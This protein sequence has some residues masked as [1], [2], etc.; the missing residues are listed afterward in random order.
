MKS[1]LTD[2]IRRIILFLICGAI[3]GFNL[4]AQTFPVQIT[5]TQLPPY[6]PFLSDFSTPGPDRLRLQILLLDSRQTRYQVKLRLT[7]QGNG[8]TIKSNTAI[9]TKPITLDY[10]VPLILTNNELRELFDPATLDFNGISTDGLIKSGKLPEGSY[11][12]CAEVYDFIRDETPISNQGCSIAFLQELDP[13]DI[14]SPGD[15]IIPVFPQQYLVSWIPRHIGLMAVEYQLDIFEKIPGIADQQ[16]SEITNPLIRYRGPFLNYRIS[17]ED[18]Q[19]QIGKEY[20]ARV[21]IKDPSG[22]YTFKND[23]YSPLKTFR[24]GKVCEAPVITETKL[25][26]NFIDVRWTAKEPLKKFDLKYRYK[27]APWQ[28]VSTDNTFYPIPIYKVGG[29]YE[30]QVGSGCYD[31]IKINSDIAKLTLNKKNLPPDYYA[32]GLELELEERSSVPLSEELSAGDTIIAN[33]MRLVLTSINANGGNYSGAGA[34]LF[35]MFGKMGIQCSFSGIGLNEDKEL[36]S[37]S[38]KITGAG[39]KLLKDGQLQLL[40]GL[41]ETLKTSS[42]ILSMATASSA[43]EYLQRFDAFIPADIKNKLDSLQDLIN[44]TTDEIIKGQ[45]AKELELIVTQY[46]DLI[47]DLLDADFQVRFIKDEYQQYGFDGLDPQPL[48]SGMRSEYEKMTIAGYDYYIPYKSLEINKGDVVKAKV[49]DLPPGFEL[50]RIKFRTNLS[51]TAELPATRSGN[52]WSITLPSIPAK[53]HYFVL[54]GYLDEIK[55]GTDSAALVSRVAGM[56]KVKVYPRKTKSVILVPLTTITARDAK[57]VEQEINKIFDQAIVSWSVSTA[58]NY[59][60]PGYD[61]TLDSIR[62][63]FLANYTREMQDIIRGYEKQDTLQYYLFI[64]KATGSGLAGFMPRGRNYGFI[65]SADAKTIAHEL[66][67]GYGAL[68]HT[69][70]N[71]SGLREGSTDL[72]MDYN[73]GVRLT[74]REW[75]MLQNPPGIIPWFQTDTEGQRVIQQS[76]YHDRYVY[77]QYTGAD[78]C[79]ASITPSGQ[80]INLPSNAIASYYPADGGSWPKGSLTGFVI[81]KTVYLGWW[82]PS[83]HQFYGYAPINDKGESIKPYYTGV[84]GSCITYAGFGNDLNCT[85]TIVNDSA[86]GLVLPYTFGDSSKVI[87]LLPLT[88]MAL[89]ESGKGVKGPCGCYTG[90]CIDALE[91]YKNHPYLKEDSPL[92]RAICKNPCL[93][94]NPFL[95]YDHF[96]ENE[97]AW[98]N[99]FNKVFGTFLH[100]GM[101]PAAIGAMVP[102]TADLAGSVFINFIRE[103][104]KLKGKD[105]IIGFTFDLLVQRAIH[106]VFNADKPFTL[107]Y[108]QALASAVESTISLKSAIGEVAV[109]AA[110]ECFVSGHFDDG[111]IRDDFDVQACAKGALWATLIQGGLKGAGYGLRQIPKDKFIDRLIDLIA[112]KDPS[113]LRAGPFDDHSI[114]S[115]YKLFNPVPLKADDIQHLFN[116]SSLDETTDTWIDAFNDPAIQKTLLD[117]GFYLKFRKLEGVNNEERKEMLRELL[118]RAKVDGDGGK[119][120]VGEWE[121]NKI[122]SSLVASLSS[123]QK[124]IHFRLIEGGTRFIE[125]DNIIKYLDEKGDEFARIENDVFSISKNKGSIPEPS[126]YLDADYIRK[127]IDKFK[128]EGAGFIVVKSWIEFGSFNTM[129]PRKFVGLRSEMDVVIA[130]YKSQGK[131][132]TII[133]DE[134]NLG[135]S[136]NLEAEEVYYINIDVDDSRFNYDIPNGNEVGAIIGEWVPGGYTKSGTTE[137]VLIGSE[138]I[139]HNKSVIQLLNNFNGK[140]EKIR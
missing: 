45:V 61:G 65:V 58:P 20:I 110:L 17:P 15:E 115:I 24:Y 83:N 74:H 29:S 2:F 132:W 89:Y 39:A 64:T 119:K 18:P 51:D 22:R 126:T 87:A 55:A 48:H 19:L 94:N 43:L 5:T 7:I 130:K 77:F 138:I 50:D 129:P 121:V 26:A 33:G 49:D 46:I 104:V 14:V 105:F 8:I 23:G 4:A 140:W 84:S 76:F 97:S 69:K 16:L 1:H 98:L 111:K 70:E 57:E 106:D 34:I 125:N 81:D 79:Y 134:L 25:R 107:D 10:N 28:T 117:E 116:T 41:L 113:L 86:S 3:F 67:H 120:A 80:K 139:N 59:D 32:C 31:A 75:E 47:E 42:N 112:S 63:G 118:A 36:I 52:T 38:I 68:E 127:H 124:A 78:D 13:P 66:G 44:T 136:T 101:A 92:R 9:I 53:G 93:L 135:I 27:D 40:D 30:F 122:P 37:G 21:R 103:L 72:L 88:G 85:Q 95:Q 62:S 6:T 108:P 11:T 133:R 128:K 91:K 35:P 99:D 131:D 12:I 96:P 114:W 109:S 100:I 60:P 90:D 102:M 123:I 71:Y 73:S 137:A 54:A 82:N 56:L